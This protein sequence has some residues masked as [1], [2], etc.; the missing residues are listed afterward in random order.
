M[1]R[2]EYK[3]GK[4]VNILSILAITISFFTCY[5]SAIGRDLFI[6]FIMFLYSTLVA[7]NLGVHNGED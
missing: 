2:E 3:M 7:Y 1:R 5:G 4:V 6:Y